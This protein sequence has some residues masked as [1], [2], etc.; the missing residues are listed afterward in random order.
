MSAA[1][2]A[3]TSAGA[4]DL[5]LHSL[6][7]VAIRREA[8]LR[9]L[10]TLPDDVR[11][12]LV[13][14]PVGYGK[15]TAVS[16]WVQSRRHR[17]GWLGVNPL[18]LDPSRLARDIALTLR[19]GGPLDDAADTVETDSL[20][21]E[22]LVAR[23]ATAVRGVGMPVLLVL[24]DLHLL[25]S[26]ASLDL[27]VRLAE[28]LPVGSRIV[29][30]AN[31]RPPWRVGRLVA[32]GAYVEIG[33]GDLAFSRDEAAAFLRE[34]DLHLPA[35]AVDELVLRTEGW[36][37]GLLLA[38]NALKDAADPVAAVWTV[39]G[40]SEYFA[41]YFRDQV[42][43]GLTVETMRF[44]MY[45]AVLDTPSGSLCDVA[46]GTTGSA[47]RLAQ[48]RALGLFLNPQDDRGE[49]FRYHRLFR[50]ML[51]AELQNHE[52]GR[53]RRILRG[54]AQWYEDQGRPVE[55]IDHAVAGGAALAAARLIVANTQYLN[56][57]GEITRVRGWL[58]GLDDGTFEL[59]PPLAVM[60]SWVYALTGDAP[61]ARSAL[62]SAES[63][64][65]DGPMPDG[66]VSLESA[67]LRARAA[68]APDGVE[69]MLVDAERAV[70]LEPAGGRWHT[71]ASLML[72]SA[73]QVNGHTTDAVRWFEQAARFGREDQRPGALTALAL[74]ALLAA[75][76]G[77]WAMAE[78]CLRD[79]VDLRDAGNLRGYMPALT[80]Y[81]ASARVAV[82][83][84]D[85]QL[86]IHHLRSALSL[87]E[88]PSPVA[89]PWLAVQAA[90]TLGQLLLELGDSLGAER[91]IAEARRHLVVLSPAG[92]L[93]EWVDGLAAAVDKALSRSTV[94]K[95]SR[96]TTAE[97]R[98]LR[99]LPSY[100]SLAQIADELFVSRNTVKSQVA[101]I[102]SKLGAETRKDAVRRAEEDG[103]L[104]RWPEP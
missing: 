45:T 23:T 67:V 98:V 30:T 50:E 5:L 28:R 70:A 43:R 80:S 97:L 90:G 46:L 68:L 77:D 95:A 57:R 37:L 11:V 10:E 66:S 18:H 86:A 56:G 4:G 26:R 40:G 92:A 36:P 3:G 89:F 12:V 44:L 59:Y 93:T 9:R 60:A 6:A 31:Q 85:T 84:A 73:H 1:E 55:A 33:V 16:Q 63:A 72:G 104:R 71:M 13:A 19:R 15:T 58:E 27:V 39:E 78:L 91:K 87:Y 62:R 74:H 47:I 102:Y 61:R 41:D 20:S 79:A 100:L 17:S 99:L 54:A 2:P 38:A 82:H 22:D 8:L 96:L 49:W 24:D 75:E 76:N 65:F 53:D 7:R 42:L 64:P 34:A 32:Q 14:A 21:T 69:R 94:E 81:L 52:P 103:L 101:A 35:D 48:A 83:R 51:R 25:R 29:A 88:S